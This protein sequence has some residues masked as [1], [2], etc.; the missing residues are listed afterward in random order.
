MLSVVIPTIAR[1]P[2][3]SEV[4][5]QIHRA[6]ADY[7]ADIWVIVD[8][9]QVDLEDFPKLDRVHYCYNEGKGVSAARNLGAKKA[10]HAFVLFMDDDMW[11]EKPLLEAGLECLKRFYKDCI[12]FNW[13]IHP[14]I[15]EKIKGTNFHRFLQHYG[16]LSLEGKVRC[17]KSLN[18][19]EWTLCEVEGIGGIY[20]LSKERFWEVGGFDEAFVFGF[21][22]WDFARRF[23]DKGGRILLLL[24]P[25]VLHYECHITD[26]VRWLAR[27][28][29][30]MAC[31]RLLEERGLQQPIRYSWLKRWILEGLYPFRYVL[32]KFVRWL[33]SPFWDRV[34][35]GLL[36]LLIAMALY[37]GYQRGDRE[38]W[39]F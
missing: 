21:E 29:Q 32:I 7:G 30:V 14:K 18:Y 38:S 22:D 6:T 39:R 23:R 35:F 36:H 10:K 12:L 27:K 4:I 37:R 1:H 2:Y 9:K 26:L 3:V 34:T 33:D 5:K 19:K 24:M 25:K 15:E 28:K 8:N 11:V 16:F 20:L 17:K 31:Q 13:D